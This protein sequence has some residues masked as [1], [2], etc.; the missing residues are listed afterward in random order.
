MLRICKN[1]VAICYLQ[2][3]FCCFLVLQRYKC[4]EMQSIWLTQTHGKK[5]PFI[6]SFL[7]V[8]EGEFVVILY[9]FAIYRNH[10]VVCQSYRDMNTQRCKVCYVDSWKKYISFISSFLG[11]KE[12]EFVSILQPFAIYRNHAVVCQSY[13]DM[14]TQRCKVFGLLRYLV[15]WHRK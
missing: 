8:K 1:C 7:R 6:S 4:I 2:E 13:R 15:V 3:S 11:V 10:S 12:G 5:I 9:P 14:N